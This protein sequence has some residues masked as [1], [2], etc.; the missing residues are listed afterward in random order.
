MTALSTSGLKKEFWAKREID[1]V[2]PCHGG[3][4]GIPSRYKNEG[5]GS[6]KDHTLRFIREHQIKYA[7]DGTPMS[8]IPTNLFKLVRFLHL[9][10]VMS[11]KHSY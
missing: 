4:G 7:H 10:D 5:K 1:P 8:G 3:G 11:E 2:F 9:L 6:I